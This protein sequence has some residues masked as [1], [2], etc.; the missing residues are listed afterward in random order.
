MGKMSTPLLS[1]MFLSFC[2]FTARRRD[3]LCTRHLAADIKPIEI[4]I[5]RFIKQTLSST[6]WLKMG[7]G[8]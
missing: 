8:I 6:S 2:S 1:N 3:Y 4:I 5:L 7:P